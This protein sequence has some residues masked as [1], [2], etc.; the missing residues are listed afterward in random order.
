MVAMARSSSPKVADV[1]SCAAAYGRAIAYG[2][3]GHMVV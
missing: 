3:I 2:H 1:A